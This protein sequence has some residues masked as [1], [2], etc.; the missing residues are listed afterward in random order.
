M[1][2]P[3]SVGC[4]DWE[5]HVSKG[6]VAGQL[7]TSTGS[8]DLKKQCRKKGIMEIAS[9]GDYGGLNQHVCYRK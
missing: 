8:G 9:A 2:S 4:C 7:Q 5:R 1:E 6:E 3:A